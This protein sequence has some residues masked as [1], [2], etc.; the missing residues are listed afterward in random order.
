MLFSCVSCFLV[1]VLVTRQVATQ[2]QQEQQ[3][4]KTV[5]KFSIKK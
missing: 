5:K 1:F 3:I 4:W 2:Q